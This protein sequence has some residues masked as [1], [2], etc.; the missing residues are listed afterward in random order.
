MH[1]PPTVSSERRRHPRAQ[2]AAAASVTT[3]VG[4]S[5]PA[6]VRDISVGG[7]SLVSK[8]PLPLGSTVDIHVTSGRLR[9]VRLRAEVVQSKPDTGQVG[10]R[11]SDAPSFIESLIQDT[12][13]AELAKLAEYGALG[14]AIKS[15]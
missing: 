12:V 13:L 8:R 7:A 11:F 3:D 5:A 4:D 9:G 15:A 10:V 14:A 1:A 2:L 6:S